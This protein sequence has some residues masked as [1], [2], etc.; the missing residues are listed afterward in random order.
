[1]LSLVVQRYLVAAVAFAI[2]LVWTG[3]SF[4]AGLK[5]LL[6]FTVVYAAAAAVQQRR[7]VQDRRAARRP[8]RRMSRPSRR[9]DFEVV[10]AGELGG[11]PAAAGEEWPSLGTWSR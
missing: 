1:V 9:D 10:T 7:L 2:A 5:C 6:A 8:E 4:T 11:W 3:V